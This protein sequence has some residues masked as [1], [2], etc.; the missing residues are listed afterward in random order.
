MNKKCPK[1][2][3]RI[4]LGKFR[5]EQFVKTGD[6]REKAPPGAI[7]FYDI[8]PIPGRPIAHQN[9]SQKY[10]EL[11]V[12]DSLENKHLWRNFFTYEVPKEAFEPRLNPIDLRWERRK[13]R[14]DAYRKRRDEEKAREEAIMRKLVEAK[15]RWYLGKCEGERCGYNN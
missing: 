11:K 14:Q 5:N 15:M 7:H 12:S 4:E 10:E 6:G 13:E 3:E 1:I 8:K 2:N 9:L